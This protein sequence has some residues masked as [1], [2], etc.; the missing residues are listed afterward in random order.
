MTTETKPT[1]PHEA[2]Y[3]EDPRRAT[4]NLRKLAVN[5]MSLAAEARILR[6]LA[7]GKHG[8]DRHELN[9]HRTGRLR[10]EA[11]A[12]HIAWGYAR[13]RRYEQIEGPHTR[14]PVP[15]GA[16]ERKIKM[17]GLAIEPLASW[18]PEG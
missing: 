5:R 3:A 1:S 4:R 11:R 15:R 14:K 18:L 7:K 9:L 17:I 2:A 13:G 16:I 12:A 10:S 8:P 6:R